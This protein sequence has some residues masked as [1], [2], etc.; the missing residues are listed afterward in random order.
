VAAV[1]TILF[2]PACSNA[3]NAA[4]S[5]A[6][7]SPGPLRACEVREVA[8]ASGNAVVTSNADGSLASV[9]VT[10]ARDAAANAGALADAKRIFGPI[11]VDKHVVAHQLKWGLTTYTDRCGRPVIP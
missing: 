6:S 10:D 2:L 7:A 8:F 3:H 1:L 9:K 5:N 11:R 4:S